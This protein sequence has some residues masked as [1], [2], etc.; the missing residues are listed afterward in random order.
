MGSSVVTRRKIWE[1]ITIWGAFGV[2]SEIQRAKFG[3]FVTYIFGGKI[4]GSDTNFRGNFWGHA[5]SLPPSLL[6]WKYPLWVFYSGYFPGK[7]DPVLC[8][9]G[10][11]KYIC[12][13]TFLK[14]FLLNGHYRREAAKIFLELGQSLK[15]C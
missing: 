10:K 15:I 6:K 9:P 7:I 2:I 13:E 3:V 12:W 14:N 8:L 4:W 1:R 11:M 5:P